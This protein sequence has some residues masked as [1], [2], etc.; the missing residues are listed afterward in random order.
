MHKT[1]VRNI[2]PGIYRPASAGTTHGKGEKNNITLTHR[3]ILTSRTTQEGKV[4]RNAGK[5]QR[6]PSQNRFP[7]SLLK[8]TE[9]KL[10]F[11]LK[12]LS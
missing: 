7:F 4:S 12:R 8:G 10:E 1:I 11:P 3:V 5:I 9:Q 6:L 2:N